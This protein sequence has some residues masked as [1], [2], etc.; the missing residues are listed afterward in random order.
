MIEMTDVRGIAVLRQHPALRAVDKRVRDTPGPRGLRL[1]IQGVGHSSIAED[2]SVLSTGLS[3][4][5][6][7]AYIHTYIHT[8]MHTYMHT[9]THTCMDA[10]NYEHIHS[11]IYI[12]MYICI[13]TYIYVYNAYVFMCIYIYM[14]VCVCRCLCISCI[15][16]CVHEQIE[17]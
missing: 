16:V 10:C 9:Y 14:Y 7:T 11:Y 6:N 8:Y 2:E 17:K 13:Y 3:M 1:G 5:Q 15:Y 4:M 12:Q